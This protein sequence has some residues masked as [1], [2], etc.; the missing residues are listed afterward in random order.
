[1]SVSFWMDKSSNH[2]IEVDVVIVGGGIAGLSTAYWLNKEDPKL[3][4]GL[5]EK[6]EIGDGA[7]GR[8]AGFITCGSVEHFN[9]LASKHGAQEAETIWKFSEKNLQLLKEHIIG[10]Y[11]SLIDYEEKGSYSLAST[12]NEWSELQ[13]SASMMKSFGIRVEEYGAGD[14]T[15]KL[16]VENFVGGIKY[17]DDAS[18][19]PL[20]MLSLLR[21]HLEELPSSTIGIF[22][23][24]EVFSIESDSEKKIT[25]TKKATFKSDFVILAT[26][27][28]SSLLHPYFSDKIYPTRGQIL[29]TSPVDLFMDGPCYANFVLDYFRQLPSGEIIIGGFRQLQKD[30]EVGFSDQTTEIIQNALEDFMAKYLPKLKGVGITHRWSGVMGFS[31]DGQPMVGC[32]PDD[33]SFYFLGGFTGHGLG[34]AFHTAK[35]LV[36]ALFGRSVPDFISARRFQKK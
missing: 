24:A 36:D 30:A 14:L 20:K 28:Y 11:K 18:V 33:N 1:M 17:V 25:R 29:A 16:G 6:Y 4:I 13:K 34:L 27:A 19:H 8:N 35:V 3:K 15:K 23:N 5:V 22:E 10:D 9:R 21:R 32:L 26:N 7:T 31:F 2:H 12:Q